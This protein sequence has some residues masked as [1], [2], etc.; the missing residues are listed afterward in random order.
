M[1][2]EFEQV[3]SKRTDAEL[4]QIMNS[5]PGD[6]QPLAFEAANN[7]FKKRCLSAGQIRSAKDEI[8]QQQDLAYAQNNEPLS[9]QGKILAFIIPR[10]F[11]TL[12]WRTYTADGHERKYKERLRWQLYG[13][14]FYAAIILILIA[15]THFSK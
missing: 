4:L 14:C 15:I 11:S 9:T 3:M 2:N 7:E 5:S 13:L 8:K 1:D 6:Y 10:I 12:L